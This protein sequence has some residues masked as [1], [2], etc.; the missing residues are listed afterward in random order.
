MAHLQYLSLELVQQPGPELQMHPHRVAGRG[1]AFPGVFWVE[2]CAITAE[3]LAVAP[4]PG[5]SGSARGQC[6]G[7]VTA[8]CLFCTHCSWAGLWAKIRTAL[9]LIFLIH[10]MG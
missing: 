7:R 10:D 9:C 2:P 1:S 8:R 6:H 3:E 4:G 5:E